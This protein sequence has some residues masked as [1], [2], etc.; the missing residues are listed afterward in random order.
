MGWQWPQLDYMQIICTSLHT[1]ARAHQVVVTIYAIPCQIMWTVIFVVLS[2]YRK[3]PQSAASVAHLFWTLWHQGP[4]MKTVDIETSY[5]S[6]FYHSSWYH[7]RQASLLIDY[8]ETA[9]R[10]VLLLFIQDKLPYLLFVVILVT[11]HW[12][13][14]YYWHWRAGVKEATS[15][16]S[17]FWWCIN[18]G[19]CHCVISLVVFGA[20]SSV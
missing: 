9:N 15:L 14:H 1:D 5:T 11:L 13:S 20:L 8:E 2:R 19:W 3:C 10:F 6:I 17:R 4:G 16:P 18:K 12:P 7:D